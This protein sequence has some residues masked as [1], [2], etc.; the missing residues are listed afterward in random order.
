[1]ASKS[2][3][4]VAMEEIEDVEAMEEEAVDEIDEAIKST[5]K[6][7]TEK[8][9]FDF[10]KYKIAN[11]TVQKTLE[12]DGAEFSVTVRPLS[13]SK[14]N[15]ILSNSMV[16]DS[17]G[18]TK[19]NG[20]TYV[21]ECLKEMIVDAPWGKTNELFLISIDERLGNVLETLVPAAFGAETSGDI[22]NLDEG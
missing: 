20:D 11:K 18:G 7:S 22:E 1:M 4:S 13:W 9:V 6:R 17:D 21:R 8:P 2:K 5:K 14:R 16:W 10:N 12:L 15:Q 3:I 19:F